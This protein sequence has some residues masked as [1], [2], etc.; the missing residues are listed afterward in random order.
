[1]SL[2]VKQMDENK[3]KMLVSYFTKKFNIDEVAFENSYK[4]HFND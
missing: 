4:Y 3:Y 1:M 2:D